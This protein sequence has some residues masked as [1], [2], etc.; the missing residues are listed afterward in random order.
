MVGSQASAGLDSYLAEV[1][2]PTRRFFTRRRATLD[3]PPAGSTDPLAWQAQ[4]LLL[5]FPDEQL[6]GRL[7]LLRLVAIT[8]DDP[9]GGP[10]GRF[11]DH[12]GHAPPAQLATEYSATFE[13][14]DCGLFLTYGARR[15]DAAVRRLEKTYAAAGLRLTG[16]ERP[17]HLGVLLEYAAAEPST[18]AASLLEHLAALQLLRLGLRDTQS[19]WADVLDS[20]WA[21]LPPMVGDEWLAVAGL[22]ALRPAQEPVGVGASGLAGIPR[23]RGEQHR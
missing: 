15:R 5:S 14:P 23:Q 18:G 12:I 6:A 11:V 7:D 20:V 8:L 16:A 21:T 22:A 10:L 19:P 1:L 3:A 17:D 9:V 2:T 13:R 4:S